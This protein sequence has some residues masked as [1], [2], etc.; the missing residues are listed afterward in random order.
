MKLISD[1]GWFTAFRAWRRRRREGADPADMGTAWGLDSIT[2]VD[3]DEPA[4]PASVATAPPHDWQ[5]R[6]ARRSRL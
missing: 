5:R 2:I 6:L 4:G 3:F 1:S